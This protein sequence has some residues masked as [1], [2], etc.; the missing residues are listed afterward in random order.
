[1]PGTISCPRGG[2]GQGEA[3]GAGATCGNYSLAVGNGANTAHEAVT[4]VGY[5]ATGGYGGLAFG[6][7]ANAG[8]NGVA[9]GYSAHTPTFY[10]YG[11]L[12]IGSHATT[13]HDNTVVLGN[14]AVSTTNNQF[15]SGS[16]SAPITTFTLHG[17][18]STINLGRDGGTVMSWDSGLN[19]IFPDGNDVVLG[20][21]A[22]TLK[23]G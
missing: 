2:T 19:T 7:Y 5:Q 8:W 11:S 15:I 22:G 18:G 3:F 10:G 12:A 21:S 6:A 4:V 20:T 17:N 16:A 9:I 13:T 1:M 23:E 14:Y